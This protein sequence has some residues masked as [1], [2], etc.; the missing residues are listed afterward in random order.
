MTDDDSDL[1]QWW[2]VRRAAL[3][4]VLGRADGTVGHALVPFDFGPDVGGAADVLYFREH[5]PGVAAVTA[6]LIGRNDQREN[7]LGNYEL[8]ICERNDA[9]WG[10]SIISRLAHYTLEGTIEPGE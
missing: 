3:E 9:R 7:R 5:L 2:D 10:T 8:M 6:E 1:E 4:Q